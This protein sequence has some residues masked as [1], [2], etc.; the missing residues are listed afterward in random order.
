MKFCS[1]Q[2]VNRRLETGSAVYGAWEE[3][4]SMQWNSPRRARKH[5]MMVAFGKCKAF[6]LNPYSCAFNAL[7]I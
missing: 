3:S 6:V 1:F 4:R 7:Y 5:A 2:S